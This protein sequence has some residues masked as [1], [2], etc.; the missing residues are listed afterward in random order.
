MFFRTKKSGPR[1][2]LQIAENRREQG[3]IK[4]RV[5]ATL[6][7]LDQL[8]G[9]GQLDSL[10]RSGARFAD[11]VLL[12]SAHQS[13]ELPVV[14]TQRIGPALIFERLW[15][16]TGC[17][18]VIEGLL[19]ERA[20]E[21]PVERAVFMAVLHRLMVSGSDRAAE[22]WQRGYAIS[23]IEDFQ[24]HHAYRAMGWL[25]EVLPE[26]QQD[27]ATPFSPRCTKDRIE[28]GLFARRRD[29]FTSLDLVFFDTTSIYF[30]G[31]G[32]ETLG[33][34]GNSKDHRRDRKQLVVGAI[35]DQD[36]WPVCCEL[37]PGNTTDV[38]TLI[39][40]ADRLN[41]RFA[42]G[43]ICL[44]ADRGMISQ[45]TI[46][47][48]EA[49]G[50]QYILG[51]RMR[52]QKE[53]S[54]QV[55][56]RAGRYQVVQA[57]GRSTKDPS[58]L[59]VKQVWVEDRRYIVCHNEDQAKKDAAD[60]AA[61][62][63]A[64]EAK[65]KQG[66]KTLVGNKGYRKYIQ[67]QG[68]RFRIDE[69]KVKAEIRYDG[70]WVLRTNTALD[71]AEVA[72]KYK[73]LWMVEDI[74]RSAKSL[75]ETRPIFH[76]TDATIRGHVF[77]S[78]LALVLR[79]ALQDRLDEMGESLEWADVIRDLDALE[80]VEVIHHNKRFLLRNEIQGTCGKVFQSVG[81]KLPQTVRQADISA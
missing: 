30:E 68:E 16:E 64:L 52:R 55:L 21:F 61:I 23:G 1:T 25:G 33:Q 60:R 78:F 14:N 5:I 10:L 37:W 77:C 26:S 66:D 8:Q 65:L 53:L 42:I 49:R 12:L 39:P 19:K 36:G 76:K 70:K 74:F 75:L 15:R 18:A 69:H 79:K 27:G 67:T 40:I 13:G 71:T 22:K 11:A 34:Y 58:P 56:A 48:L 81:V 45:A 51:A 38:K 6:G 73:Q 80:E 29:L 9:S 59:K 72:L 3:K 35:L 47:E 17:Q 62:I 44:V 2:Y 46:A 28:E 32:G 43:E 7:R 20:F 50:W 54:E 4:Q 41:K 31:E 57:K 24:L 63:Q